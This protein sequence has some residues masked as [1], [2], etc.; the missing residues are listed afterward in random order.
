M[1]ITKSTKVE[2]HDEDWVVI[3]AYGFN[4]VSSTISRNVK[5]GEK[6][7]ERQRMKKK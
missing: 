2:P 1:K 4:G 5:T 6:K 7:V 3:Y